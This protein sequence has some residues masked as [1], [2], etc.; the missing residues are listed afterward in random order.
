M[1]TTCTYSPEDNKL[2]LTPGPDRLPQH[3]AD[4]LKAAG[5]QWA[6]GQQIY[7]APMWTPERYALAMDLAGEIQDEDST[8]VDRAKFR[9]EVFSSRAEQRAAD[10]DRVHDSVGDIEGTL[11]ASNYRKAQKLKEKVEAR[12][13][14]AVSLFE[15]STYWARRAQGALRNAKYKDQA[16]VR[17][18]RIKGLQADLRKHTKETAE[19]GMFLKLWLKDDLDLAKATRIAN[20][21]RVY[22]CYTAAK[23]PRKEGARVS[24]GSIGLWSALTDEIITF[25]Q[26]REIA[27]DHHD[28]VVA[29]RHKW[30]SHLTMRINYE[31]AMLGE[32]GG[33][34]AD[35][36]DIAVGGRVLVDGEW[37]TVLRVT[38][39][40]GSVLSVTT[41]ARYVCVRGIEEVKGY[42]PP[43]AAAAAAVKSATK[44][45]PLT[46]Y[47][48]EGFKR[49]TKAEWD[50]IY[51]DSKWTVNVGV[52]TSN[53]Y[54]RKFSAE[55]KSGHGSHRQRVLPGHWSTGLEPVFLTDSKVVEPPPPPK[56]DLAA[57][58]KIPA[59]AR[60]LERDDVQSVYQPP[61]PNK[62]DALKETLRTGITFA[63]SDQ[64]FPT[65]M[66]LARRMVEL[67]CLF[68]GA[69]VLEPSAGTGNL[70]KA[71][72]ET[73]KHCAI[74]AVEEN[75]DLARGLARIPVEPPNFVEA[76]CKDFLGPLAIGVYDVVL[77]NPPFKN[78]VDIKHIRQARKYLRPG[79]RLVAI[80]AGGPRQEA[81]LKGLCDTWERLPAG[82]FAQSGT[83]VNTV[84]LTLT[85]DEEITA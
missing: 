27:V 2:R 75:S 34:E 52:G 11:G 63:V 55:V 74:V 65:P 6:P 44:L 1:T 33:I 21:D 46:N 80:C 62:F 83:D 68:D 79:G 53:K 37:V 25:E 3:T 10:A 40:E 67:A 19:S 7:I 38:K 76:I 28:R 64:L 43:S 30:I 49:M 9:A 36:Y 69:R 51:K 70:I 45:A 72:L 13:E 77:M 22:R 84:L 78:G 39:R 23:Y 81:E 29:W 59:P 12:L 20:H 17:H 47:D 56:S 50:Q 57:A 18:R 32:A 73:G 42:E 14:K 85:A 24:E 61:A 35:K 31:T 48:G 26:A 66:P 15:E 5:F 71:V 4:A 60:D 8:L 41:N 58:V 16:D 82:T 54:E